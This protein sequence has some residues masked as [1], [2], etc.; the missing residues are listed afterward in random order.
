MGFG[1][2]SGDLGGQKGFCANSQ[3]S[4]I[5]FQVSGSG[6]DVTLLTVHADFE[7]GEQAQATARHD[8]SGRSEGGKLVRP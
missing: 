8:S 6:V 7:P 2:V 1:V 3:P 4:E 5:L